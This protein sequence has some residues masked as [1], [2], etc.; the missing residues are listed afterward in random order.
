MSFLYAIILL[1][2]SFRLLA[3]SQKSYLVLKLENRMCGLPKS[4]QGVSIHYT[5]L[6]DWNTG[7]DYWTEVFSFLG[8]NSVVFGLL[9]IFD[10]QLETLNKTM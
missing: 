5:G 6:L 8:Q 4:S 9:Q 2:K 3:H 1:C 10:T 7:L